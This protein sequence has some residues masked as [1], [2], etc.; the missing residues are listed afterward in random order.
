[1]GGAGV[2]WRS[3]SAVGGQGWD[4]GAE[5]RTDVHSRTQCIPL[6]PCSVTPSPP[7]PRYWDGVQVQA[8][9]SGPTAPRRTRLHTAIGRDFPGATATFWGMLD[10]VAAY[11]FVWSSEQVA[12]RLQD[13]STFWRQVCGFLWG[14]HAWRCAGWGRVLLLLQPAAVCA[15]MHTCVSCVQHVSALSGSVEWRRL[16]VHVRA[17][18]EPPPVDGS[19]GLPDHRQPYQCAIRFCVGLGRFLCVCVCLLVCACVL[20]RACVV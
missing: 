8:L 7:L 1:V 16:P 17:S 19:K 18:C 13:T 10:A 20:V 5:Y 14:S 6:R 3:C 11:R 9:Y 2:G 4:G 15:C 12:G